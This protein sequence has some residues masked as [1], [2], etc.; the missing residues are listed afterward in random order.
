MWEISFNES[1]V[2]IQ[3]INERVQEAEK[4]KDWGPAAGPFGWR[5]SEA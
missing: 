3:A 1:N 4:A 2:Q 5:Q